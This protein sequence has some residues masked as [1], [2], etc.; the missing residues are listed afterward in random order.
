MI[1][2]KTASKTNRNLIKSSNEVTL[3]NVNLSNQLRGKSQG[4]NR[5]Q[6]SKPNFSDNLI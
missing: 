1:D 4:G 6:T 3:E 2:K 5:V